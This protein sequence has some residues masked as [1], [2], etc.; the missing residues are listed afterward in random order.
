M[1]GEFFA[2]CNMVNHPG[3]DYSDHWLNQPQIESFRI[4]SHRLPSAIKTRTGIANKYPERV[5]EAE[6]E[7]SRTSFGSRMEANGVERPLL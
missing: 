7:R 4:V 6:R 2:R 3:R 5:Q 1:S